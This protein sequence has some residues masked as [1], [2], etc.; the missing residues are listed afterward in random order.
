[1][2]VDGTQQVH[3]HAARFFPSLPDAT[4]SRATHGRRSAS[5]AAAKLGVREHVVGTKSEAA[6]VVDDREQSLTGASDGER[7]RRS[8]ARTG[9]YGGSRVT[10]SLDRESANRL[11]NPGMCVKESIP[12]A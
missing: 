4:W 12:K 3:E 10:D 11:D 5:S 1:M 6:M 9:G 8:T 2:D 7:K